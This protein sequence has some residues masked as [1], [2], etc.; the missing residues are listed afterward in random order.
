M[1]MGIVVVT[2][3][4][5]SIK[6]FIQ[7]DRTKK[8]KN[9]RSK[10]RASFIKDPFRFTKEGLKKVHC[11]KEDVAQHLRKTHSVLK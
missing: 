8:M 6:T 3:D 4:I 10:P 9:K 11:S 1:K 7:A 5:R 2:D